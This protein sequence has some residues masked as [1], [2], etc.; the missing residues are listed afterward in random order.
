[1]LRKIYNKL[2]GILALIQFLTPFVKGCKLPSILILFAVVSYYAYA[3]FDAKHKT[4]ISKIEKNSVKITAI[5]KQNI[6][7][8]TTLKSIQETVR[9]TD[10]RLWYLGRKLKKDK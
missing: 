1:M 7:V 3:D 9:K 4:A 8:L 10:D 2:M 5:E 6:V